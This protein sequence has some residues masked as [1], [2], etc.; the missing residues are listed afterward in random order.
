MF[1][2]NQVFLARWSF[3]V[4]KFH[5]LFFLL[6][7]PIERFKEQLFVCKAGRFSTNPYWFLTNSSFSVSCL[8]GNLQHFADTKMF[9]VFGLP[10]IKA[11]TWLVVVFKAVELRSLT[12]WAIDTLRYELSWTFSLWRQVLV[13]FGCAGSSKAGQVAWQQQPLLLVSQSD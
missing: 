1:H 5:S 11:C 6:S 2:P 7:W 10:P 4:L 12:I 13:T 8:V 3:C 9:K